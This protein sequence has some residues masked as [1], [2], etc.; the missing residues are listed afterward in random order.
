MTD[1]KSL[2]DSLFWLAYH[3]IAL[4]YARDKMNRE[5]IMLESTRKNAETPAE[6]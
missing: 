6:L 4:E 5:A 3:L 2:E 1:G